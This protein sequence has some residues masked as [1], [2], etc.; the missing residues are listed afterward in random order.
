[1]RQSR[2]GVEDRH[3]KRPELDLLEFIPYL[4]NRVGA[5]LVERFTHDALSGTH[6]T[7][8]T[9]RLLVVMWNHDGIR[10]VDLAELTSIEVSTVSRLVTRLIQLGLVSRSRS[11]KSSREVTVRLTPKGKGL[12]ASL[13]PIAVRL[14]ETA[15]SGVSKK[16]LAAIKRVLRQMHQNLEQSDPLR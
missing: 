3:L 6:L 2:A 4:I 13:V 8:G 10:Q 9:W 11:S 15:T 1:L 16:E 12:V 5:A 14:E 7:I